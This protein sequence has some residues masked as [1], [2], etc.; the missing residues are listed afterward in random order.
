M[1]LLVGDGSNA[2]I[3]AHR[4]S[5]MQ[6]NEEGEKSMQHGQQGG[7]SKAGKR[8]NEDKND[9]SKKIPGRSRHEILDKTTFLTPE[10]VFSSEKIRGM[11]TSVVSGGV[12]GSLNLIG[13]AYLGMSAPLSAFL[14][15]Y[16]FG[17]VFGY[18]IDI[19]FAKNNF[20]IKSGNNGIK[21]FHGPVPYTDFRT[22][23]LWLLRSFIDKHFFRFVI[24][25][26]IDTLI[27]LS[28]LRALIDYMNDREIL[29]DFAFRD[30]LVAGAV[31]IFTFFLYNN[32]LRF[33]WAY[34]DSEHPTMNVI[35]LMWVGIVLIIF[36]LSYSFMTNNK[37]QRM[38]ADKDE[39][40][41]RQRF[42]YKSIGDNDGKYD[43]DFSRLFNI[44]KENG[45]EEIS[46]KEE[47]K[48]KESD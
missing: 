17:S 35:V 39:Q 32:V 45:G 10:N 37:K 6:T 21:P 24:T 1:L 3:S 36:S 5:N 43:G 40:N 16:V 38:D 34:S 23:I 33:D 4:F 25:V 28:I 13:V 41:N 47:E 18:S 9:N 8:G 22:R 15:L 2:Q 31:S 48:K 30:V 19:L 14:F 12:S 42:F 46:T 11:I 20:T 29:M 27:G 44:Q 7:G 26:I